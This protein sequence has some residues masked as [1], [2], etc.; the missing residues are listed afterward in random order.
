MP[1]NI[2]ILFDE[3]MGGPVFTGRDRGEDTRKRLKLDDFGA[4]DSVNVVI[5][6]DVYTVTS[7]YFLGLFGPSIR[8]LGLETFQK[9]F[10]FTAPAFLND[11]I[12]EWSL[13]AVRER[14][15]LFREV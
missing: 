6:E 15:D 12:E 11:H 10:K 9:I 1:K 7:S 4:G 5:P 8:D 2:Q 14:K 13:R 3:K